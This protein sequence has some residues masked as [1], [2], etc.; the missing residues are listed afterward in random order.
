M[1]TIDNQ[2]VAKFAQHANVWWDIEGPLKTLHDINPLRLGF[3][4]EHTEL[5]NKRILDLGCGGGILS[6]S[7]AKAGAI[8]IGID[9]EKDAISSAKAHAE[10]Q[11]LALTYFC[12]PIEDF[13]TE[14]FDIIICMEMLEH[15]QNPALVLTHCSRLLKPKG[16]LFLS[17]INRSVKAYLG[18]IV[19]AEYVL[20]LLPRQ[21]HDYSKFIK[22]SE[23]ATMLRALDLN[24]SAIK[25]MQYNPLSR[26]ASLSEDVSINYLVRAHSVARNGHIWRLLDENSPGQCSHT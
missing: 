13:I 20:N 14:P 23:L 5:A 21:T 19:V 4:V 9:A 22:P 17:T 11:G 2:E 15:V 25:G 16:Q 12:T 1:N 3:I 26:K 18:A 10:A 6:E 24:I 7:L 8:V